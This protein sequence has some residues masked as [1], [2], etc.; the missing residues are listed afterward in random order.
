[1]SEKRRKRRRGEE[2]RIGAEGTEKEIVAAKASAV[3]TNC[4]CSRRKTSE[5]RREDKVERE[6]TKK[7]GTEKEIVAVKASAIMGAKRQR[8][9]EK[10]GGGEEDRIGTEKRKEQ[11]RR[12]LLPKRQRWTPI[13]PQ[14]TQDVREEE[15]REESRNGGK[16]GTEKEIVGRQARR[17]QTRISLPEHNQASGDGT[18]SPHVTVPAPIGFEVRKKKRTNSV[19]GFQM[20]SHC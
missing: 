3:D 12:K 19:I 7:K 17:W 11:R 4:T 9:K 15:R 1:M 2:D 20:R 18:F 13:A 6:G 10:R 14:Q 16:K 8:R 5:N